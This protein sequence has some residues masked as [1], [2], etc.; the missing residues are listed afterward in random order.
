MKDVLEDATSKEI[1]EGYSFVKAYFYVMDKQKLKE[2]EQEQF[3]EQLTNTL[4]NLGKFDLVEDD[5]INDLLFYLD[6]K[7]GKTFD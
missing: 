3:E 1:E 7:C 6:T 4:E 2:N 5:D